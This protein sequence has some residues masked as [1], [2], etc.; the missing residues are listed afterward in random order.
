MADNFLSGMFWKPDGGRPVI[1]K[2]QQKLQKVS[3]RL[4]QSNNLMAYEW[5]VVRNKICVCYEVYI[6][7]DKEMNEYNQYLWSDN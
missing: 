4:E 2:L 7:E 5:N 6:M 3:V 1:G